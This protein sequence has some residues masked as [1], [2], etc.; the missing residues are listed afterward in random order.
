M[1]DYKIEIKLEPYNDDELREVNN[2]FTFTQS[3]KIIM[4]LEI[5]KEELA[6][7]ID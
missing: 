6:K 7:I 3:E 2:T 5:I 1:R 4:S